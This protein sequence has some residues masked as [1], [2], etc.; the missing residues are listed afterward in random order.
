[1]SATHLGPKQFRVA[2]SAVIHP[3]VSLGRGVSVWDLSQIRE[4]VRI[5]DDTVIG[6]NV[7]VDHDVRIGSGC[8]IQNNVLVYSPALIGDGV[9]LGPG[10]ILTNDTHPRAVNPDGTSKGAAEWTPVGVTVENGA[11]I[12]AGAVILG[13]VRIGSWSLVGAGAVVTRDVAAHALVLGNPARQVG[14]VGKT[15]RRLVPE[16]DTLVD[17]VDGTRFR[18]IEGYLEESV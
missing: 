3:N 6:R 11:A 13:G 18:L 17:P 1:M 14:W 5:G 16:R 9:F 8:K 2:P 4:G 15:G 12:G 10:A 7:Y